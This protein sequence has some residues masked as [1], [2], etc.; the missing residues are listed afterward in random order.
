MKGTS[1]EV[2]LK[3]I[4]EREKARTYTFIHTKCIYIIGTLKSLI[5]FTKTIS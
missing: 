4:R 3:R 5:I 1:E 2:N